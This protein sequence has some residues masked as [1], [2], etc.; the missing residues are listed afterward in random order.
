MQ[1]E[2]RSQQIHGNQGETAP[3]FSL[4]SVALGHRGFLNVRRANSWLTAVLWLEPINTNLFHQLLQDLKCNDWRL[5]LPRHGDRR[6][7][8]W[9]VTTDGGNSTRS[10]CVSGRLS[11]CPASTWKDGNRCHGTKAAHFSHQPNPAWLPKS[12]EIGHVQS[13]M[14]VE[15]CTFCTQNCWLSLDSC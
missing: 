4:F 15:S 13:G 14:A 1:T 3:S 6:N 11:P 2:K 12:D 10:K 5:P 7:A 8:T 9:D